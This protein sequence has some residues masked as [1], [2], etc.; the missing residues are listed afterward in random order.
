MSRPRPSKCVI[1]IM[2]EDIQ[3]RKSQE[4]YRFNPWKQL[5]PTH[6]LSHSPSTGMEERTRRVK[7]QKL[8][9]GIKDNLV[10]KAKASCTSNGK[11]K[12]SLTL[13]HHQAGVQPS[14]GKQGA[15]T[16]NGDLGRQTPLLQ[17]S[18]CSFFFPQLYSLSICYRLSLWS[19][20][21]SCPSC[22]PS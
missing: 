7:T 8:I 18:S 5:S 13:S 1:L 10:G 2:W 14:P 17:M 12:D 6:P 21:V 4:F 16:L 3:I 9:G 11:I 20:R 22:A 19:V 15:I